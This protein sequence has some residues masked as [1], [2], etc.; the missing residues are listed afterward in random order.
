VKE[1]ANTDD[2][3][4]N[5]NT[6]SLTDYAACD[7]ICMRSTKI[8]TFMMLRMY[9]P[10]AKETI[11]RKASSRVGIILQLAR[12][13]RRDPIVLKDGKKYKLITVDPASMDAD[14]LPEYLKKRVTTLNK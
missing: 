3:I 7:R 5:K 10:T 13:L 1:Q 14:D 6:H 2:Q 11:P 12:K 9:M 4:E 8:C